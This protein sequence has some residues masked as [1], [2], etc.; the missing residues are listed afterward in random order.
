MM[1][2]LIVICILLVVLCVSQMFYIRSLDLARLQAMVSTPRTDDRNPSSVFVYR[3]N[4]MVIKSAEYAR[5]LD[6]TMIDP[7]PQTQILKAS[8]CADP[9]TTNQG[10]VQASNICVLVLHP[11]AGSS[12]LLGD[13]INK[14]ITN[15]VIGQ[16]MYII[17][18]PPSTSSDKLYLVPYHQSYMTGIDC[19]MSINHFGLVSD[20]EIDA[21]ISTDGKAQAYLN[22]VGKHANVNTMTSK[23]I[24]CL[25]YTAM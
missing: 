9:T 11:D 1:V 4:V 12:R 25:G 16:T 14:V 15:L 20:V 8:L 5:R 18:Q 13:I 7:Y 3:A 17:L 22:V 23:R 24:I 10:I 19:A 21:S 2:I 6:D